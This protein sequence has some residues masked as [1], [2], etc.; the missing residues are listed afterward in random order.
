MEVLCKR[1]VAVMSVCSVCSC[2]GSGIQQFLFHFLGWTA[3]WPD[4]TNMLDYHFGSAASAQ[5]GAGF[6]DIWSVLASGPSTADAAQR[7][8]IYEQA[9]ELLKQHAPMIPVA[10]AT[11][12][13][14]FRSDVSGAHASPLGV[15]RFAAMDPGVR[16]SLTFTGDAE[17]LGL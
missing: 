17:P 12:A 15:E 1:T 6:A 16:G 7:L 2:C 10:H 14:A 13:V 3:D 11:D 5:F 9:A 8:D 4:L